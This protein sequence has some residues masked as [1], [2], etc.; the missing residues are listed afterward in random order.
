M[1]PSDMRPGRRYKV[2]FEAALVDGGTL[3]T[4]ARVKIKGSEYFWGKEHIY[5]SNDAQYGIT[6][7]EI[8]IPEPH[9]EWLLLSK[10]SN[11]DKTIFVRRYGS[12]WK[13]DGW[14]SRS[15]DLLLELFKPVDWI[16]SEMKLGRPIDL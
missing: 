2:T 4:G 7:E 5:L 8:K 11:T 13:A 3:S 15:W 6:V 12:L 14:N 16:Y 9:A 10:R 1:R